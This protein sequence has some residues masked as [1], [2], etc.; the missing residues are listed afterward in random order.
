MQ[1]HD[2]SRAGRVLWRIAPFSDAP[3]DAEAQNTF[4]HSISLHQLQ[5]APQQLILR[6]WDCQLQ[7]IRA[8]L[9]PPDMFAPA[10]GPAASYQHSFEQGVSI[11]KT[12]VEDGDD[13]AVFGNELAVEKDN[14]ASG[15]LGIFRLDRSRSAAK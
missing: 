12:T 7:K 4:R 13:G 11:E 9:Q 14:H 3:R 1:G 10:E 2:H 15:W 8:A 5:R 6:E